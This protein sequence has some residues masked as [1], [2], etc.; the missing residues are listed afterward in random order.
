MFCN[1]GERCSLYTVE[2]E[3]RDV[4]LSEFEVVCTSVLSPFCGAERHVLSPT[5]S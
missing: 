1:N 5:E 2:R 3:K 4:N